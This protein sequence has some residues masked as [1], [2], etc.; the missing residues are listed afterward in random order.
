MTHPENTNRFERKNGNIMHHC[1]LYVHGT[2]YILNSIL[3]SVIV[4]CVPFYGTT[5]RIHMFDN[6]E[7]FMTYCTVQVLTPK[8]HR[9]EYL[10]IYQPNECLET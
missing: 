1:T 7:T 2:W 10:Y 3:L 6:G 8:A 9:I 4:V 5:N